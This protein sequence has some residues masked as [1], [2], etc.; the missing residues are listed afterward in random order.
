MTV[1]GLDKNARYMS[2]WNTLS[3]CPEIKRYRI[4]MDFLKKLIRIKEKAME[5][6]PGSAFEYSVVGTNHGGTKMFLHQ[7]ALLAKL[8]VT[9]GHHRYCFAPSNTKR[10]LRNPRR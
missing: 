1:N 7:A 9:I 5:K 6:L 10:S 4:P 2:N 8:R 3:H